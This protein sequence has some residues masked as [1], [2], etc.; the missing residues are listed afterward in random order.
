MKA[1]EAYKQWLYNTVSIRE[2]DDK[3]VYTMI[4]T[5]AGKT[6]KFVIRKSDGKIIEDE[7]VEL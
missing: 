3:I 2:E 4:N 6:F 7:E 5:R 1:S